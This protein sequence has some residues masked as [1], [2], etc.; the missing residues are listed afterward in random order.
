MGVGKALGD[1][2]QE[3]CRERGC[4][5][6]MGQCLPGHRPLDQEG[7]LSHGACVQREAEQGLHPSPA[8]P[9]AEAGGGLATG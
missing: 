6:G 9:D 2:P 7:K 1:L 4:G 5:V 3:R 8:H